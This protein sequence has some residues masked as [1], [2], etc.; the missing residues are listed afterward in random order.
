MA[1]AMPQ[2]FHINSVLDRGLPLVSEVDLLEAVVLAT[3]AV[4]RIA[5]EG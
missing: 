4:L 2:Y 3:A 5:D 1:T